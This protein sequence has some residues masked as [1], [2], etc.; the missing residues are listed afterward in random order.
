MSLQPAITANPELVCDSCG[1]SLQGLPMGSKCPECGSVRGSNSSSSTNKHDTTMSAQAPA[2]F[3]KRLRAGF[4]LC[5]L[6]IFAAIG[7]PA[8]VGYAATT[9]TALFP[10]SLA[11]LI[12][13]SF[14]W[15]AG[16][17]LITRP[18]TGIGT[19]LPDAVL[20]NT[21]L[22]KAI[23][24]MSIAWPV[25]ILLTVTATLSVI[26][27]NGTAAQIMGTANPVFFTVV[28]TTAGLIAWVSLI[29]SCIYFAELS[30]WA[31][32]DRLVGR[33]RGTAWVMTVSGIATVICELLIL[34]NLPIAQPARF[35]N[36]WATIISVLATIHLFYC[37]FRM[38]S[39]LSWVLSHQRRTANKHER[40]SARIQNEMNQTSG[41][42]MSCDECGY[43]LKGLPFAGNCPE[44]GTAYGDS[45][46]FPI[47]DPARDQPKQ[48][49]AIDIAESTHGDIRHRRSI[50]TPL[51]DGPTP[52][53]PNPNRK[54]DDDND[55]IPLAGDA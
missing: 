17:W 18:R 41:A 23:R 4:Y 14:S 48:Q 53:P 21:T 2:W 42:N 34:S 54:L 20:D 26:N 19:V 6:S 10:V 32:D 28:A 31:S 11:V 33:L 45:T 55:P 39:L 7:G 50:G 27:P 44:C 29:P 16:I 36:L 13:V 8:I 43:N 37:M 25:W 52:P 3:V 38:S 30:Y 12:A 1:Y 35:V 9:G 46:Q 47:R 15:T 49:S 24:I 51:E 40:I 5:M 22:V